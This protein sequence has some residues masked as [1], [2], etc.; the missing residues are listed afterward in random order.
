MGRFLE[1]KENHSGPIVYYVVVL[2]LGCFPWSVFL[3]LAVRQLAYRLVKGATWND[4]D[5]LLACWAGVW[6]VFFSLARTKLPNYVL[7]MYPVLALVT[8]RYLQEWILSAPGVGMISFR[9]CCWVLG[10]VGVLI[11]IGVPIAAF[12]LFGGEEFLLIVGIVPIAAGAMAYGASRHERRDRAVQT[13]SVAAVLMATL[14]VAIAPTRIGTHLDSPKLVEAARRISGKR[15]LEIATI[16]THSPS[17]VFYARTPV[18]G[19]RIPEDV[20]EFFKTHPEGFVITR[21]DRVDRLPM[22][23]NQ[24]VEVSRCRRFL[25]RHDMVLLARGLAIAI[26][27]DALRR[28]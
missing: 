20:T 16:G 1:P 28:N 3:P 15:R 22:T 26:Q 13:L 5:R 24:L 23:E 17:L 9:H 10:I 25:R 12:I 2:M 4:S 14:V 6:L 27:P 19:L 8:A 21:A 11:M 18:E 7:P